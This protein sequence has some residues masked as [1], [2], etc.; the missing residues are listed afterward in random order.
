MVYLNNVEN[1]NLYFVSD[2]AKNYPL[3]DENLRFWG[4]LDNDNSVRIIGEAV[5]FR[6]NRSFSNDNTRRVISLE[7]FKEETK[8]R[9]E[10][11]PQIYQIIKTRLQLHNITKGEIKVDLYG[12]LAVGR[13]HTNSDIDL[14]MYAKYFDEPSLSTD[15]NFDKFHDLGKEIELLLKNEVFGEIVSLS[16]FLRLYRYNIQIL[17]NYTIN[18]F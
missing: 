9:L 5:Y 2:K 15:L 11:L 18:I 3:F 8:K 13:C 4:N 14:V 1:K 16:K 7:E 10:L 6:S 12:S 17:G